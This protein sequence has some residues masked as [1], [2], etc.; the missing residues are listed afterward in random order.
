[1]I[2]HFFIWSFVCIAIFLSLP[3]Y[4][5]LSKPVIIDSTRQVVWPLIAVSS[6]RQIAVVSFNAVYIS[7]DFGKTFERRFVFTPPVTYWHMFYPGGVVYDS[8]GAIWI[9]WFWDECSDDWCTFSIDYWCYL[10]K[11]TDS[12]RT[13]Q[14]I[15]KQRRGL[16]VGQNVPANPLLAIGNDNT[17]H[18]LYDSLPRPGETYRLGSQLTYCKLPNGDITQR[19]DVRLPRL[20]DSVS[21]N[22]YLNFALDNTS[23]VHILVQVSPGSMYYYPLYTH[24]T[25]NDMFTGYTI[26]DPQDTLRQLTSHV[27]PHPV[28]GVLFLYG[29]A[30]DY[31]TPSMIRYLSRLYETTADSLASPRSVSSIAYNVSLA[32]SLYWYSIRYSQAVS[33]YQFYR[34][35]D[36]LSTPIDSSLINGAFHNLQFTVD[37]RGGK[38]IVMND[39]SARAYFSKKDVITSDGDYPR[40]LPTQIELRSVPN[41]FNGTT[42][43]YFKLPQSGKIRLELYNILGKKL[44]DLIDDTLPSGDHVYVLEAEGLAS[45]TYFVKLILGY[46]SLTTKILLINSNKLKNKNPSRVNTGMGFYIVIELK[47]I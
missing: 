14:H 37:G 27:V 24:T 19:V 13:F 34:F 17:V 3:C 1:M 25:V 12:G 6:N 5:Q 39:D 38:Y 16:A 15:I 45:G 46:D 41:P 8:N 42:T 44:R 4:T 20:P 9:L 35:T 40:T 28:N 31:Y 21:Y 36:Y 29:I 26:L 30:D 32:D 23:K 10:S 2:G 22:S 18:F 47:L 7:E 43:L 33:G 11:S